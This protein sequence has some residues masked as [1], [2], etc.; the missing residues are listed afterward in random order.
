VE[1]KKNIILIGFM[2]SGK[3]TVGLNLSY[4]M[5][6]PV[7]DTDKMIEQREGKKISEIFA[8]EGEPYFRKL[9]TA[10]LEE[11]KARNYNRII[12]VGG[13]TPVNPVNRKLLKECGTVIYFRVKPETVYQRV[14]HDT[15]RPLLQSE[16]PLARIKELMEARKEA[17]EECADIIIDVDEIPQ[18]VVADR[19]V[20]KISETDEE[21]EPMKILVINGPNLNF[22]GIREKS[23]YGNQDYQ[24]LLDMIQ[25]K[26]EDTGNEITVFQSNHEGAIIDRIQEAYFDGTQGIVINP[27]AYTHYSYAI[28]DAL[29]SITVPKVEIHISDIT[30]REEFR[31]VSVTAPV[32][33]KQIYGQ[34]LDGYLQAIDFVIE[35]TF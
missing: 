9:E 7:E 16:D 19:I 22:L 25:K 23:V 13:G 11:I 21:K 29:A 10:L 20:A 17:Y 32:C 18:D 27:G 6:M 35:T 2:G 14:K 1:R 15:A 12:S 4:K 8:E 31:K 26:A 34:G 24:Y 5:R 30:K 3:T 28:R 33:D